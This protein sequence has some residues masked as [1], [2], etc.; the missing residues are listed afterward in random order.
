MTVWLAAKKEIA[1]KGLIIVLVFLLTEDNDVF[2]L[3]VAIILVLHV[4]KSQTFIAEKV[5]ANLCWVMEAKNYQKD[6]NRC[7]M[8]TQVTIS[9]S[10]MYHCKTWG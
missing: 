2:K 7:L 1:D 3:Q 5:K 8:D 6:R 9:D 4:S 10:K